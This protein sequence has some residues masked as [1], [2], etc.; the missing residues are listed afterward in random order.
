MFSIRINIFLQ[1]F[2]T[3]LILYLFY[4]TVYWCIQV[5]YLVIWVSNNYDKAYVDI[6]YVTRNGV[7]KRIYVKEIPIQMLPLL[8]RFTTKLVQRQ[9]IQGWIANIYEIRR[10]D[11]D[12]I[13]ATIEESLE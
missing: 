1:L 6:H 12:N 9:Y 4:I 8:T 10:K 11:I 3:Y 2:Y 13:I 5:Y 7:D